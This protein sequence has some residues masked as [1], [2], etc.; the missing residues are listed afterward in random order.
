VSQ[1]DR[2]DFGRWVLLELCGTFLD[3]GSSVGRETDRIVVEDV[4]LDE[5]DSEHVL[6][7]L[8]RD[9][10]RPGCLFGYRWPLE[11]EWSADPLQDP[12]FPA[13]LTAVNLRE[14][15]AGG[16]GLPED[17]NPDGITWF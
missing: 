7:V 3:K 12:Y 13:M 10:S 16:P 15:L 1:E 9:E 2:N 14:T 4:Y 5:A 8:L 11:P 17:C 6:V